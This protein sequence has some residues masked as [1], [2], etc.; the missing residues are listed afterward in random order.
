MKLQNVKDEDLLCV[1][2]FMLLVIAYIYRYLL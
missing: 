2:V 1:I